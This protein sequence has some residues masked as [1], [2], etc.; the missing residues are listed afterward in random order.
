M[1][2]PRWDKAIRKF[3]NPEKVFGFKDDNDALFT[4]PLCG[5]QVRKF[6]TGATRDTDTNKYD[7]EAFLSPLVIEAFGRYMHKNRLQKDGTLRDG[8]NWQKG[9]PQEAYIKSGFRHFMEWWKWHRGYGSPH[10]A[11]EELEEALCALIF[12][13]QGYLH[14]HLKRKPQ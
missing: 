1:D 5:H 4:D 2:D 6:D 10:P 9:I 12:N 8:D 14:E 11:H 7:Y 3:R 13:A